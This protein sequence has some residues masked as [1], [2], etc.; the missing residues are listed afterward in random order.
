VRFTGHVSDL[1]LQRYYKEAG[2]LIFPS[3][4]EGFGF[5]LVEA[6]LAGCPIACS[7]VSSLPEVAGDAALL[8]NPFSV[9]D[10][11]GALSRIATDTALRSALVERGRHRVKQ[12]AGDSCAERTAAVINFLSEEDRNRINKRG[13]LNRS[14]QASE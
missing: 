4:Y 1:E 12:Y 7:N 5:P 13:R 8:F 10:I 3:F 6:M 2:A 11:A 14:E 9:E